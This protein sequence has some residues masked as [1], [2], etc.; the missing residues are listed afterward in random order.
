M[1][2]NLP[3]FVK[4]NQAIVHQ[5]ART[6]IDKLKLP[7]DVRNNVSFRDTDKARYSAICLKYNIT[8]EGY[9]EACAFINH[10]FF[11]LLMPLSR[12]AHVQVIVDDMTNVYI[13][14]A[15]AKDLI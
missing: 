5:V 11:P 9:D 12:S 3:E 14:E 6:P 15:G 8:R 7:T 2:L 10:K 13:H 1:P 4:E